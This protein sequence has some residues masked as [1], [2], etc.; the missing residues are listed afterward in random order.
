MGFFAQPIRDYLAALD[1]CLTD[2]RWWAL[3]VMLVAAVVGWFVYVPIHE[4]LHAFGCIAT[5]GTVTRLEIDAIYGATFLQRFFPWIAVGS[6]Y[7]GQLTGFDTHGNDLIYLATDLAPFLLTVGLGVPLLLASARAAWPLWLRCIAAG[8]AIPV[9][10]AP[11]ISLTGDYYE[12]GSIVVSRLVAWCTPGFDVAI[13]RSDDLFKLAGQLVER[14]AGAGDALG[15]AAAVVVGAGLAF[16][17][18]A[19]GHLCGNRLL[20]QNAD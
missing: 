16:G 13:W 10:Y 6:E 20:R 4:L 1:R 7:A 8:A 5:G 15:V 11:F 2:R 9:A 3:P 14:G 17:T 18:Y 12:M 19:L